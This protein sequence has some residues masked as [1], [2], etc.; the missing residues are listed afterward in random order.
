MC[1]EL[2]LRSSS[3]RPDVSSQPRWEYGVRWAFQPMHRIH[4]DLLSV[5]RHPLPPPPP[6]G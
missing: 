2:G 5:D 3:P 4:V 6:Q 1:R